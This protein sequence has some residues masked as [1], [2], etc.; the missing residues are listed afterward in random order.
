MLYIADEICRLYS[1]R[2]QGFNAVI[3]KRAVFWVV[4][5]CSWETARYFAETNRF[6]L[7]GKKPAEAGNKTSNMKAVCSLEST[8]FLPTTRRYNCDTVTFRKHNVYIATCMSMT[9][10]HLQIVTASK[11]NA[12]V[13]S[14]A[15]LLNRAHTKFS[16]FFTTRFLVKDPNIVFCSRPYWLVN[17]PQP[18]HCFN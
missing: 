9:F 4:M 12:L 2:S 1:V 18:T 11:H 16:Q 13:N 3:M 17:V 6:H 14:C 7:Q 5:P 8:Y 10:D 15:R